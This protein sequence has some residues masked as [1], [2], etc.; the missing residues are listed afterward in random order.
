M[1]SRGHATDYS[2]HLTASE[3]DYM[4]QEPPVRKGFQSQ[5]GMNVNGRDRNTDGD[6]LS[7]DNDTDG[8]PK[9][10]NRNAVYD[11]DGNVIQDNNDYDPQINYKAR[12]EGE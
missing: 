7:P 1:P 12:K 6:I 9:Q 2:R 3:K 5:L 4:K 8:T 11:K 10:K